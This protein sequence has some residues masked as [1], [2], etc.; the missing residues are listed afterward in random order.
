MRK[1]MQSNHPSREIVHENL[2]NRASTVIVVTADANRNRYQNS[3]TK[4]INIMCSMLRSR[5]H[6]KNLIVVA[7]S[8]PYDFALDQSMSTYV[9]SFDYTENAMHALVRV[10]CGETTARATLPGTMRRSRKSMK[11]K[12]YWLVEEYDQARDGRG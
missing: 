4:H 7:V 5:G 2:L 1:P 9:C 8:S 12:Q 3:F 10:L 6:K 11:S